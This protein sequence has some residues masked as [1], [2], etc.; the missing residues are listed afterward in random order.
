MRI[1]VCQ[2]RDDEHAIA[3]E[4]EALSD[5]ARAA[6]ADL[7]VLPE[8]PFHPWMFTSRQPDPAIWEQAAA[9]HEYWMRRLSEAEATAVVGSRPV[10]RSGR[11]LNEAFVWSVEDGAVPAH[12]KR[13][14]PDEEGFWE[15]SWYRPGDGSFETVPAAS[16][17]IGFLL[18]SELWFPEHARS[19]GRAGAQI[20]M[21]SRATDAGSRS[22][23]VAGGRA[24]AVIAGAFCVSSNRAG[25]SQ[26]ID[27]AGTGWVIDPDGKVL[28]LTSDDEPFVTVEVDVEAADTAKT[29]Y[30]RYVR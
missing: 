17:T 9:A 29:T 15:A 4:W 27:W 2:L 24:T 30:P 14:L 23:W 20:L 5:H 19:Y 10:T 26:G 22:T 28:A 13:Y 8:L 11:R 12:H 1:T 7:V 25:S 21:A 18:C 3:E 6:G 16:A